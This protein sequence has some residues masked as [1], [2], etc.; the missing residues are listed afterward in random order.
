MTEVGPF[1]CF[2]LE[3]IP[4][5]DVSCPSYFGPSSEIKSISLKDTKIINNEGHPVG[6]DA[7]KN[8]TVLG[9]LYSGPKDPYLVKFFVCVISSNSISS[10]GDDSSGGRIELLYPSEGAARTSVSYFVTTDMVLKQF[11]WQ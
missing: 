4:V 5:A 11:C 2:P 1:E 3:P 10:R 9:V 8:G 6:L 7:L